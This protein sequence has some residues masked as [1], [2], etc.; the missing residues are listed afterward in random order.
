M[1]RRNNALW[2]SRGTTTSLSFEQ[3]QELMKRRLKTADSITEHDLE[4]AFADLKQEQ[5]EQGIIDWDL[6][7]IE[8]QAARNYYLN[9]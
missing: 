9:G 8:D 5:E 4:Q 7:K 6:M 2:A 3:I 1:H